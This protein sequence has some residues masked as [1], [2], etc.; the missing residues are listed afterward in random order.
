[1]SGSGVCNRPFPISRRNA[2]TCSNAC[3]QEAYRER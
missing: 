1:M 3:R 2:R